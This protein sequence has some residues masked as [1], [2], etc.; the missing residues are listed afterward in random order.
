MSDSCRPRRRGW[1]SAAAL[2]AAIVLAAIRP[3]DGA[4]GGFSWPWAKGVEQISPALVEAAGFA[5]ERAHPTMTWRCWAR[6]K[7]ALLAA[8]VVDSRPTSIWANRAGTELSSKFG[9]DRIHPLSPYQA[10]V[11]AILVYA[12]ADGG[13]VEFRCEDGFVSD[14]YS[15]TPY[16]RPLLGVY[17]KR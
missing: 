14:F 1:T 7:D 4:P 8:G 5:R 11:G 6:V 16:P 13:H 10:P 12:G 9:F 15:P 3:A 17:V 2:A